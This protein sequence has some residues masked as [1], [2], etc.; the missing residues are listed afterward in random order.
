MRLMGAIVLGMLFAVIALLFIA[1]TGMSTPEKCM[2][3]FL[4]L[5]CAL[6]VI[7]TAWGEDA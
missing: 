4:V 2:S 5:L 3:A 7:G 6:A 1:D